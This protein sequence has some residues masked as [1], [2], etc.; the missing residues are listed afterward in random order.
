[1]SLARRCACSFRMKNRGGSRRHIARV[2]RDRSRIDARRRKGSAGRAASLVSPG[3]LAR[4]CPAGRH[5][6]VG[7]L[8]Q[9]QFRSEEQPDAKPPKQS[10]TKTRPLPGTHRQDCR[11]ARGGNRS[12]AQ[13]MGPERVRRIDDAGQRGDRSSLSR[14][15]SLRARHVTPRL[16]ERRSAL[17]QLPASGGARMAGAQ[18]REGD[19]RLFLQAD[20]N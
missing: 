7:R 8:F 16:Y 10:H 9:E 14:R 20:R 3:P 1:M 19:A 13:A 12:V 4:P 2:K 17:V 18:G 11:R 5:A 15:Q 6:R